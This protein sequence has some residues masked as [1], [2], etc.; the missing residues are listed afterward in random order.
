MCIS[1]IVQRNFRHPG[2]P[3]IP[4]QLLW[5][6]KKTCVQCVF[7]GPANYLLMFRTF[8]EVN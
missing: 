3:F 5:N 2:V 8:F 6:W 4:V 7:K 1:L